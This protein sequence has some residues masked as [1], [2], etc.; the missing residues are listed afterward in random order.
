MSGGRRRTL[1]TRGPLEDE[2]GHQTS[3]GRK[4]ACFERNAQR[5]QIF[6]EAKKKNLRFRLFPCK[7][8]PPSTPRPGIVGQKRQV[9]IPA[10][11]P[12]FDAG[13]GGG[14]VRR[15]EKSRTSPDPRFVPQRSQSRTAEAPE[16]AHTMSV[17]RHAAVRA[18]HGDMLQYF[19]TVEQINAVGA[20]LAE[21]QRDADVAYLVICGGYPRCV[22]VE[23][24]CGCQ[25]SC[26]LL[27]LAERHPPRRLRPLAP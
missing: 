5:K 2:G 23:R 19:A 11:L 1:Q 25:A 21:F 22:A 7:V 6:S 9:C 10:L 4:A 15:G 8:N 18:A 12:G 17:E 13:H 3:A 16:H 26:V 27:R 20:G 24:S 14:R